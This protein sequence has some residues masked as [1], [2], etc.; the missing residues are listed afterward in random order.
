MKHPELTS[1]LAIFLAVLSVVQLAVGAFGF[2][3]AKEDQSDDIRRYNRLFQR[4]EKYAALRDELDLNDLDYDEASESLVARQEKHHEDASQHRTDLAMYTATRSGELQGADAIWAAKAQMPAAREMLKKAQAEFDTQSAAFYEQYDQFMAMKPVL[5]AAVNAGEYVIS[6]QEAIK[7]SIS[8]AVNDFDPTDEAAVAAVN[9]AYTNA[10]NNLRAIAENP[11]VNE[12]IAAAGLNIDL[13]AAVAE[14]SNHYDPDGD[15]LSPEEAAAFVYESGGMLTGAIDQTN[16][17]LWPYV[18]QAQEALAAESM[19]EMGKTGIEQGRAALAEAWKKFDEGESMLQDSLEMIWYELGKL[20]A[21]KEELDEEKENLIKDSAEI[22]ELKAQV[23]Y[24]E[25]LTKRFKSARIN[26]MAFQEISSA[27]NDD[28]LTLD[29][30]YETVYAKLTTDA[31]H[32]YNFRIISCVLAI[33]AAIA[34][35]LTVPGAFEKIKVKNFVLTVSILC[36][37]LSLI[38]EGLYRSLDIGSVYITLI[39][40]IF[41][42]ITALTVIPKKKKIKTAE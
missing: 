12:A 26:L 29:E 30:A 24:Y 42:L 14:I 27:V 20:D 39:T 22:E 18:E 21:Q 15:G 40:P 25:D 1:A 36:M 9:A 13:A 17:A 37:V 11:Q 34:G 41:A 4:M 5:E 38:S 10:I 7:S 33:I 6:N 23:E 31:V 2:G 3:S 8:G 19:L 32:K 28:G 16:G 35:I